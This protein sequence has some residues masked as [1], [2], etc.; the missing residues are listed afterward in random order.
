MNQAAISHV[1]TSM[2]IRVQSQLRT[3]EKKQGLSDRTTF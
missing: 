2:Q 3:D 1:R